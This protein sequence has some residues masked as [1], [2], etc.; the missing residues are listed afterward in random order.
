MKLKASTVI[1]TF[2][3]CLF[4]GITVISIGL[5]AAIPSLN[6]IAK[7]FICPNG[8]M[9]LSTQEYNPSPVET[10]TTLT[11]YCL[12]SETGAKTELGIFPMCLYAGTI[13]GLSLFI[14][15]LI[16]LSVQA[17]RNPSIQTS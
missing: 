6:R 16:I 11:W 8:E 4:M 17:G 12:D 2:L 1:Q 10:I 13:Y 7:P 14:V 3:W 5:G 9:Q 15:V